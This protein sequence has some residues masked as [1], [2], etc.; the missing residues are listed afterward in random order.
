MISA[1]TPAGL[2]SVKSSYRSIRGTI[3][4]NWFRQ[5]NHLKFEIVIPVNTRARISLPARSIKAVSEGGKPVGRGVFLPRMS[6]DGRS[7]DMTVGSS[8]Y[9]FTVASG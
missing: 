8:R 3:A 2:D 1:R 7:V 4:S 5:G 6:G 9:L